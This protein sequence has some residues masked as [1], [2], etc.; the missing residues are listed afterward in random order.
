VKTTSCG[1]HCSAGLTT[2]QLW[3]LKSAA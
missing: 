3:R 1:P 2:M